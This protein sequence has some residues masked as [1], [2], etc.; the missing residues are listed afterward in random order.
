MLSTSAARWVALAS[1]ACPL[2]IGE[3][4]ATEHRFTLNGKAPHVKRQLLPATDA[5]L[6][7]AEEV[8]SGV[9][10][11]EYGTWL[12]GRDGWC[13]GREVAMWVEDVTAD[14]AL[15]EQGG[16]G[17]TA[18][19]LEYSALWCASPTECAPPESGADVF[20]Y[21]LGPVGS[22]S[23]SKRR[24]GNTTSSTTSRR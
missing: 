5:A 13:N 14:L 3:F 21:R 12:Y 20:N 10:P 16:G 1:A 4:C 18:A 2:Q 6:G 9:T 23:C 8:D 11:N 22:T 24:V 17:A 7:C 19:T 15:D